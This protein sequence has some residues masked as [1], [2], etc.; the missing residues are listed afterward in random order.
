M[1]GKEAEGSNPAVGEL[2]PP[3]EERS[4]LTWRSFLA[5]IYAIVIFQ[6]AIIWSQLALIGVSLAGISWFVMLVF[7]ELTR[8]SG[9]PPTKQETFIIYS[10]TG[11]AGSG[12]FF[13][14]LIYNLYFTIS[15]LTAEFGITDKIPWWYSPPAPLAAKIYKMR[16]FLHPAFLPILGVWV[17][18]TILG[19]AT[20]ITMG[21]LTKQLYIDTEKLPFPMQQVPASAILTLT[22]QPKRMRVFLFFIWIGLLWGALV[23]GVGILPIPWIDLNRV[24]HYIL[25]GA[26][27]GIPTDLLIYCSGF[28]IPFH[29]V[30]SMFI[31]SLA[32]Q[33]IGNSY[34]VINRVGEFSNE[35][36]PGMSIILTAQRSIL[37]FWMGP[38]IGIALAAGLIPILVRPKTL[39]Q[40]LSGMIP[41]KVGEAER[42]KSKGVISL[43]LLLGIWFGATIAS[44]I[45]V[46][47]LV[48]GYPILIMLFFSLLWSFV[49]SLTTARSIGLTGQGLD[50]RTGDVLTLTKY[51]YIAA[52]GYQGVDIWFINPVIST[53]G[54]SWCASFKVAQLCGC[55]I[56]SY[57]LAYLLAYP[58]SLIM[59]FIFVSQFWRMAPIPSAQFPNV[60]L[61]WP[62]NVVRSNLWYSGKMFHVFRV[63][64]LLA[65]FIITAVPA[66]LFEIFH[67]P[68]SMIGV[69]AGASSM[70]PV[71]F[72]NLIGALLGRFVFERKLGEVWWREHRAVIIA[73]IGLGEGIVMILRVLYNII[74]V[75]LWALPY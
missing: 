35:W 5:L 73:G 23:Y 15:P 9:K 47:F 69:A 26:S 14:N 53:G 13:V 41:K 51:G 32:V 64:H 8:L 2:S 7:V 61:N 38:F 6:P 57:I 72:G 46:H 52:S 31:G 12:V 75:S 68:I 42:V 4:G 49:W 28:I 54:A 67:V 65:S 37:H 19:L 44:I 33:V 29:V 3:E 66:A 11:L 16:T 43:W 56:K 59:G 20:D 10:L 63:E 18:F 27:F 21:L 36:F 25:P 45:I 58:I 22:E 71:T 70:I 48:P 30:V 74:A 34:L 17:I 50:A 24:I 1:S 60:A 62:I 39:I 40:A 55:T